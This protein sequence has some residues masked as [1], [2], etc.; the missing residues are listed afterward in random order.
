MSK[1]TRHDLRFH[2]KKDTQ[3]ETVIRTRL[4]DAVGPGESFSAL[5]SVTGFL[6]QDPSRGS[7][8]PTLSQSCFRKAGAVRFALAPSQPCSN[9]C[10]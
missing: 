4:C 9:L 3:E 1:K 5:L 7:G 2:V 8:L 10:T 6:Y